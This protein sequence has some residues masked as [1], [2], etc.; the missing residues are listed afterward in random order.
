MG[1][2]SPPSRADPGVAALLGNPVAFEV[3]ASSMLSGAAMAAAA[4]VVAGASSLRAAKGL[5]P[6]R[7]LSTRHS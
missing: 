5:G 4:V 1:Q 3:V 2:H 7:L 6:S